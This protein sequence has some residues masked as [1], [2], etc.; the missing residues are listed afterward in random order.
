MRYGT[1]SIGEVRILSIDSGGAND[2]VL[3]TKSLVSLEFSLWQ[4]LDNPKAANTD[5]LTFTND[6]RVLAA[7]FITQG[8]DN[9]PIF[10]IAEALMFVMENK[11]RIL[12]SLV[13]AIAT[14]RDDDGK[15]F[16]RDGFE[17][18]RKMG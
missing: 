9:A 12:N 17:G 5:L 3:T 6:I 10:T 4:K 15:E 2:G 18:R 8:R 14:T 13:S 11:Q 1:H 16:F 7:Q